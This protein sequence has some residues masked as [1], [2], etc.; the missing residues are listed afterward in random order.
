MRQAVGPAAGRQPA[1]QGQPRL[2]GAPLPPAAATPAASRSPPAGFPKPQHACT[3]RLQCRRSASETNAVE[4]SGCQPSLRGQARALAEHG[5]PPLMAAAGRAAELR[6]A[7]RGV[8]PDRRRAVRCPLRRRQAVKI[9][10]GPFCRNPRAGP[11]DPPPGPEWPRMHVPRASCPP[12]SH[13]RHPLRRAG[14]YYRP[15]AATTDSSGP[16]SLTDASPPAVTEPP[17]QPALQ[18]S[19][20]RRATCRGPKTSPAAL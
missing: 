9:W 12:L 4:A 8:A 3:S 13:R 5:S 14:S 6:E 11:R 15:A 16:A 10:V 1:V 17:F 20:P 2:A 18:P 7:K 19:F